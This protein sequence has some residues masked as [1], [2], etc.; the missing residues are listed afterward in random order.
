MEYGKTNFENEVEQTIKCR[1]IVKEILDFGVSDFQ[2]VKI[3]ELLALELESRDH[4]LKIIEFSKNLNSPQK[5]EEQKLIT[6]D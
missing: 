1:E 2:K 6:L 5:E 4:M 3:I